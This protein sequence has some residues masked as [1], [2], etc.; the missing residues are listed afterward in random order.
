[1]KKQTNTTAPTQELTAP[2]SMTH[3][4]LQVEYNDEFPT[5][6]R[7]LH[8]LFGGKRI[9]TICVVNGFVDYENLLDRSTFNLLE[10]ASTGIVINDQPTKYE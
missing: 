6:Q 8:I 9:A 4:L 10:I 2:T 7:E 3:E 5:N 1:M